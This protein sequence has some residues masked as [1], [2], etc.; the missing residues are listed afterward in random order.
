MKPR[1][2]L[3]RVLKPRYPGPWKPGGKTLDEW[4]SACRRRVF[5][6]DLKAGEHF[7]LGEYV[8]R[9]LGTLSAVTLLDDTSEISLDM[10]G[11]VSVLA[12]GVD[13]DAPRSCTFC[14][15]TQRMRHVQYGDRDELICP[16]CTRLHGTHYR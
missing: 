13:F 7:C 11:R 14:G 16:T 10:E 4:R 6:R 2:V 1:L 15:A 9:K 5:F 8:C 12:E 3:R